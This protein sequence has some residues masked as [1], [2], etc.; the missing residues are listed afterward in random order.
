MLF[1]RCFFL[2]GELNAA[3]PAYHPRSGFPQE[4]IVHLLTFTDQ[5]QRHIT[6]ILAEEGHEPFHAEG[7]VDEMVSVGKDHELP[8]AHGAARPAVLLPG[9]DPSTS[10]PLAGSR[11]WRGLSRSGAVW[12][13]E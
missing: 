10:L 8:A 4:Q 1:L 6:E 2:T 9:I 12:A 5:D 13:P 11:G 7:S 3:P